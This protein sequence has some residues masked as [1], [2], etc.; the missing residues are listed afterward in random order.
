MALLTYDLHIDATGK[1]I[2]ATSDKACTHYGATTKGCSCPDHVNREGGSYTCPHR[3]NRICKHI[4]RK[5]MQ[6]V[7]RSVALK[8]MPQ[9]RY[10]EIA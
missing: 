3:G 2:P 1:T 5:R 9:M 6:S 7:Q 10:L 8:A 4:Y